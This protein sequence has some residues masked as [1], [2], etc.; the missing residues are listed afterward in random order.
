MHE[1][2]RSLRSALLNVF[3]CMI[4]KKRGREGR[5]NKVEYLLGF[6]D[7]LRSLLFSCFFIYPCCFV[8]FLF[9]C[10]YFPFECSCITVT[11]GTGFA[12]LYIL[13]GLCG[14]NLSSSHLRSKKKQ[15]RMY[16]VL[17]PGNLV[18]LSSTH[19]MRL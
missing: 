4:L 10:N 15:N 2:F 14:M 16:R 3:C 5:G 9:L 1:C 12:S 8:Y 17:Y 7:L 19:F 11:V 13:F 18:F 6:E